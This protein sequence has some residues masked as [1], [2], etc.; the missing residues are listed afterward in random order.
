[1]VFRDPYTGA[2]EL[3]GSWLDVSAHKQAEEALRR[4]EEYF[5]SLIENAA[6]V[7]AIL[8]AD[9]TTRYVSP[10]IGRVLGWAPKEWLGRSA[11]EFVHPGDTER[12]LQGFAAGLQHHDTGK[13]LVFRTRHKSG[14]WRHIEAT[15][16]NLCDNEA[17]G[18]VVVNARDVT[19]RVLAEE[20]LRASEA[21]YRALFE[22]ASDIIFTTDPDGTYTWVNEATERFTGYPRS[23]RSAGTSACSCRP[24]TPPTRS[25][26]RRRSTRSR[27]SAR[28]AR[29]RRWRSS[30]SRCST[31]ACPSAARASPATSPSATASPRSCA[32]PRKRPRRRTGRRASSSPT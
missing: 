24:N 5:R 13:P 29:G 31:T 19:E 27:S 30:P 7:I 9:G 25:S 17:V 20:A 26:R 21:R 10:S 4:R 16:R 2:N 1:V 3:A 11:F 15:D 23:E 6:D 14:S 22:N 12:V 28:T 32:A 18:G 8:A